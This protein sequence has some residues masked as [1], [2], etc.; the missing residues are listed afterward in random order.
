LPAGF[1]LGHGFSLDPGRIFTAGVPFGSLRGDA[2]CGTFDG[3]DVRLELVPRFGCRLGLVYGLRLGFLTR[4]GL[5][6]PD[7]TT[8]RPAEDLA[9]ST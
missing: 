5:P 6:A 3:S 7:G 2:L 4:Q 8:C 9:T 1:G